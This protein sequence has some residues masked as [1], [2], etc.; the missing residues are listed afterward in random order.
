MAITEYPKALLGNFEKEFLEIPSEVIITSMRDNQRYFAVFN[1]NNLSN[2]FI[3]VSNAV[4]EDYSKVIHGNERVL[5]ARLSDAMFFWQNDLKHGLE[6]S[7]LSKMTYFEG[8]GSMQDKSEREKEVAKILC[9]MYR[10]DKKEE[11]LKAIEY[12]KADLDTQMVYEF[13]ELQGIMG[14]YYAKTM[15]LSY[16]LCLALREQYLPNSDKSELP[17]TEFSSI[18]ALANKIDTLMGLFAIGKIPSGTKDPYALRRAANGIIKITLK[19]NK[20]FELDFLLNHLAKNYPR[21]DIN[22]LKDFILERLY[23]FY[24][25]NA[26]FVKAVLSSKNSDLVYIDSCIKALI[27]ISKKD[28]FGENFSTFKRLANIATPNEAKI[29][30]SLFTHK[31]ESDLYEKFKTCLTHNRTKEILESLFALKPQIDAFFDEVMIN[32]E[33]EKLK[34]NRQALIYC[35]YKE[36]L[37]IADIKELSL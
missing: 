31:A 29:N 6:P 14:S 30:E 4:C 9:E 22:A 25:I 27:E 5:R 34:T 1:N 17:S 18:V 8:L 11:I 13:T 35:I 7:K 2:H 3:V 26:S 19:I 24:D 12:A 36:F 33:D 28:D 21:F 15:G 37:K 16:E 23:T 32:V 10:N 20:A